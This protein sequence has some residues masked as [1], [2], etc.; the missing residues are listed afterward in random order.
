[1][2]DCPKEV[3]DVQIQN[4]I[5]PPALDPYNQRV[6]RVQRVMLAA[7]GSKPVRESEEVFLMDRLQYRHHRTLNDFVLQRGD[8][9]RP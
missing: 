7:S 6:Q 9:K 1:M 3:L 8:A 4:I 2:S 5:H